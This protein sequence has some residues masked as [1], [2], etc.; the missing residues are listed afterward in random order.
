MGVVVEYRQTSNPGK[1]LLPYLRRW[2]GFSGKHGGK[3][4]LPHLSRRRLV[5]IES[6]D[7]VI[8]VCGPK[9]E[10]QP[11]AGGEVSTGDDE[12]L[13]AVVPAANT[14]GCN[15]LARFECVH[16]FKFFGVHPFPFI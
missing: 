5:F 12:K 6:D 8:D 9:T 15:Q 16:I 7:V 11:V 2:E 3:C 1:F 4:L 13:P 10:H 14:S